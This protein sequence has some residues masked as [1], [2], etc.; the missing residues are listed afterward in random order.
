MHRWTHWVS[1]HRS[2]W[3]SLCHCFHSGSDCGP[4]SN[5]SGVVYREAKYRPLRPALKNSLLSFFCHCDEILIFFFLQNCKMQPLLPLNCENSFNR[6][7]IDAFCNFSWNIFTYTRKFKPTRYILRHEK[8]DLV[9]LLRSNFQ[10]F[11]SF[12]NKLWRVFLWWNFLETHK[13]KFHNR[14]V[15]WRFS[16]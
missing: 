15:V 10:Y 5:S 6:L 1:M 13:I 16:F 12:L 9:L 8:S 3:I 4:F 11:S 2:A 7:F 14:I